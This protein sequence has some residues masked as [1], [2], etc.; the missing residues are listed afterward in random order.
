MSDAA[1]KPGHLLGPYP[2]Q[3]G[4]D[5]DSWLAGVEEGAAAMA[6]PLLQLWFSFLQ[7]WVIPSSYLLWL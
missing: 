4:E 6:E 2:Q 1:L 3:T 7:L 5:E